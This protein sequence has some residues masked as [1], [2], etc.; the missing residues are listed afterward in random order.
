MKSIYS[1]LIK[2]LLLILI[3]VFFSP[4]QT[5]ASTK[6]V[7]LPLSIDYQLLKSMIIKTAYTDQGQTAILL[8]E[9]GGCLKVTISEPSLREESAQILFETKVH[10]VA[11]TYILNNCVMPIEWEGYLE[12]VQKPIVDSK[13]NLSFNTVDDALYDKHHKPSKIAG[14]VWG[15]VKNQVYEYLEGISINL[16]PPILELK[17]ILDELI[18]ID[19]QAQVQRMLESMRP[20][21]IDTTPGALQ[22][23]ILAEVLETYQAHE[24]TERERISTEELNVFIDTWEA[25]DSFLVYILTSLSKEPLSEADRHVFLETLLETR[26]RFV[27]D[28][29]DGTVGRDFVREQFISA[30][31]KLSPIFR[32]QLGDD[33]SMALFGYLAFF[34]AADALSALD[35]ISPTMGIEISRN[36]LIRLARL[37]AKDASLTLEYP[38]G[39]NS[40]LRRMF[41]LGAPPEALEPVTHR[42]ELEIGEEEIDFNEADK[43]SLKKLMMSFLSKPAW[44]KADKPE[45]TFKDIK[46]WVFSKKNFETYVERVKALLYEASN[47]VLNDSEIEERYHDLY[48]LIVLSTAW[49][50]SCF[51][52]FRV[53]KRKVVYL[54]S[55]NR[56]SVGLMQINERVW[57]GMYDRHH[58]RWNIRYNTAAGCEIIELYLRKYALDRIK[59]MKIEKTLDD[60][61]FARIVYAMYNGGP[62]QFKKILERKSKGTF[63]S[64]DNLYFEKYSWVKNSQWEN[65]RKCLIGG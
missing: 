38:M 61:S 56:T 16:A 55:Y 41:G 5:Q 34:T 58:L 44:A 35:K 3:P 33:P 23:D 64:S 27:M 15:L 18:P 1:V 30:W 24:D 36:G 26:H 25:W 62:G 17:S 45:I 10:A 29:A 20:G 63:F 6:T 42:E 59:K 2:I 11:G 37:L 14:I 9:N 60:E 47:D 8:N 48:R 50:E 43:S 53:R 49:Q 32:R 51:R 13:W 52:Q 22:I 19:F 39:V 28:L 12:L 7:S 65:I 46:P 57:R 31:E 21:E 54:L 4:I 40:E